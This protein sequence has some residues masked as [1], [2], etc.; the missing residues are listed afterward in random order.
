[1]DSNDLFS[2]LDN[3]PQDTVADN[4]SHD[5]S[6]MDIDALETSSKKR[7]ATPPKSFL[8]EDGPDSATDEQD[9]SARKKPRIASPAPVV[10]DEFETEAKREVEASAGLTGSNVEAG[11]RLELR[12]QV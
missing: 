5:D 11:S 4:R 6:R 3:V 7:K 8:V 2:F 9:P 1:M 10:V 12:H